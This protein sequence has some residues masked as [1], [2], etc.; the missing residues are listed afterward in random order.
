M[1]C[2]NDNE[3]K[4]DIDAIVGQFCSQKDVLRAENDDVI[5]LLFTIEEPV[6]R[7][8]HETDTAI[9]SRPSGEETASI[10]LAKSF[11][12]ERCRTKTKPH[13][14]DANDVDD[15]SNN[16]DNNH[17]DNDPDSNSNKKHHPLLPRSEAMPPLELERRRLILQK[18]EAKL[19][20]ETFR[21]PLPYRKRELIQRAFVLGAVKA[22][23]R[24]KKS[25]SKRRMTMVGTANDNGCSSSDSTKRD[26]VVGGRRKLRDAAAVGEVDSCFSEGIEWD[27][28]SHE[29]PVLE[30]HPLVVV[31]LGLDG[32]EE[33]FRPM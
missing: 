3:Q 8:Y 15:G 18:E 5:S 9:C 2:N 29:Q 27:F 14:N 22:H 12:M 4:I 13:R 1:I 20:R 30:E 21:E 25:E 19:L 10:S 6:G 32:D 11:E 31:L 16:D 7:H 24:S 26:V 28:S 17:D 23:S 33:M